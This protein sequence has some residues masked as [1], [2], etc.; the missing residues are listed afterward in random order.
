MNDCGFIGPKKI[1]SWRDLE[2]TTP[3]GIAIRE[4]NYEDGSKE[5]L[6]VKMFEAC[7][8]PEACDLSKLREKRVAPVI[9]EL[10]VMLRDWGIKLG[11][12]PYLSA[13]L[14]QSLDFNS[15]EALCELWSS[16]MPKPMSLDDV[17][18]VTVDRVLRSRK[19][20]DVATLAKENAK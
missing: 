6:S 19:A 12:L 4:V 7:V 18:L 11:E 9:K 1:Q 8:S 5:W 13:L 2:E 20:L 10:L 14:N 17:D 16:Y 3:N 15:K